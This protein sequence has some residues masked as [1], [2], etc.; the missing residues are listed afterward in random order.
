MIRSIKILIQS[1]LLR[2]HI[3][4]REELISYVCTN[5]VQKKVKNSVANVDDDLS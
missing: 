5:E 3:K 2:K 4:E 1:L